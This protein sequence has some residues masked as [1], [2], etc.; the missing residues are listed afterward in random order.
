MPDNP[1][2]SMDIAAGARPVVE[3]ARLVAMADVAPLPR[4]IA[5]ELLLMPADPQ[6]DTGRR[7]RMAPIPAAEAAG[8]LRT[9]VVAGALRPTSRK[10]LP[11]MEER[12]EAPPGPAASG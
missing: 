8:A 12:K 2:G 7:G 6:P 3:D 10:E 1:I 11:D 4:R 5:G 9:T